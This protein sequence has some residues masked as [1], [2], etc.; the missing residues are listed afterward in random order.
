MGRGQAIWDIN[1]YAV[2]VYKTNKLIILPP[3]KSPQLKMIFIMFSSKT[4]GLLDGCRPVI[5]LNAC[6]LKG[7]YG[8]HLMQ[9]IGRD[10]KKTQLL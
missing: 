8:G 5:D 3:P 10:A 2:I 6:Y 9:A 4:L 7:A 1:N